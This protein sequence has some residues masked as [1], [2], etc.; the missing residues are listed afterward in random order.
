MSDFK[1]RGWSLCTVRFKNF[2]VEN[3]RFLKKSAKNFRDFGNPR[4]GPRCKNFR[5]FR[6]KCEYKKLSRFYWS[7]FS[8]GN[9]LFHEP[10]NFNLNFE[11]F[12]GKTRLKELLRTWVDLA[13]RAHGSIAPELKAQ[14]SIYPKFDKNFRFLD[15]QNE[16]WIFASRDFT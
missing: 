1:R 7:K 5:F 14:T 3:F 8:A 2:R 11:L 13:R 10:S 16:F 15:N 6:K 9:L 4:Y 12:I